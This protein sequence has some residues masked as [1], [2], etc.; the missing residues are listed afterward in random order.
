MQASEAM[1]KPVFFD[2]FDD[3]ET[4]RCLFCHNRMGLDPSAGDTAY[5]D[6][7]VKLILESGRMAESLLFIPR[8]RGEK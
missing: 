4:V 8:P 1:S 2:D 7:C 6:R 3:E 5:C